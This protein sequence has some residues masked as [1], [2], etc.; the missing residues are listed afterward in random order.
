MRVGFPESHRRVSIILIVS[1]YNSV[2]KIKDLIRGSIRRSGMSQVS[3]KEEPNGLL[4]WFRI[5]R[6]ISD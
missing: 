4:D 6:N 3:Q 5:M 1:K 2:D